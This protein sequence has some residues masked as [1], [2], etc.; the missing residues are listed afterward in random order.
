M[1]LE[2][3]KTLLAAVAVLLALFQVLVMAQVRGKLSIFPAKPRELIRVHKQLGRATLALVTL[4][5]L[6]CLYVVF[7]LGYPTTSPH[8]QAHALLGTAA[9]LVLVLKVFVANRRRAYLRHA[10]AHGITAATLLALAF[11]A[12]GLLYL[13]NM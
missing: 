1:P 13:I 3:L 4:I 6:L 7:G 12:S 5:G 2:L 11:G 10:M 9:G 8:V